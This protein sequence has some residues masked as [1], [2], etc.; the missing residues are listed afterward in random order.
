MGWRGGR[1]FCIYR[2]VQH[3]SRA[4]EAELQPDAEIVETRVDRA[5]RG[6]QQ[7]PHPIVH[8]S[9]RR[10]DCSAVGGRA[11]G[12]GSLAAA[13][14]AAGV[15]QRDG[16]SAVGLILVLYYSLKLFHQ[17]GSLVL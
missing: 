1:R 11:L 9:P 4:A 6:D 5:L 7:K 17:L 16:A 12:D 14:E 15:R 13:G 8:A 10:A 2:G 3:P